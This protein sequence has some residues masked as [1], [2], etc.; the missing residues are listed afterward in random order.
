MLSKKPFC[1]VRASL[2]AFLLVLP[3]PSALAGVAAPVVLH[4]S[5]KEVRTWT[6]AGPPDPH[7]PWIT[8]TTLTAD[9]VAAPM[10]FEVALKMRNFPELQAR[11]ARGELISPAEMEAKYD[12]LPSDAQAVADWLTSQGFVITRQNTD[13]L[14]VFARGTVGQIRQGMQV[15]FGRVSQEGKTYTS[16]VTAPSLPASLSAPVLGVNGLQPHIRPHKH[17]II[18]PASLTNTNPPFLPSQIAQ[19]YDA[20]G[21]YNSNITGSGQ[22]I[23]IIIDTF[24]ATSDLTSFWKT[25]GI[26]QSLNNITFIQVISG[27][28]P[29]TSGE[30]TLDTE[31]SSSIAPGV[32]VR[33]YAAVSLSNV[34]LDQAYEQVYTDVT[35]HPQLGIHQMSM[36]Y[37][38]G[39]TY[40]TLSQVQTDDQYFAELA[41]VGVTVFASAGDGGSTPGS[42]SAGDETGPLQ[43][44]SPAS[45]P[46][47]TGVG[48]TSLTLNTNGSESSEAVWNN[49][50][51]STNYGATGGGTSEYFYRPSWQT[52]TGVPAG[53]MRTVPDVASP[54]DPNTGAVVV[55][56]GAQEEFGGTSWSSPTWAG[57]CALIN[58]ARANAGLSSLGLLGPQIYPLIGTA[59]FRDI[60]SGNNATANSG[61]L[62][63][64]GVGYDPCTGVGVPLVQTLSQTLVGTPTQ[65]LAQIQ[66]A[67]Q[68]IVPGQNATIGVTATGSP[69]GY[70]W[71][72]MPVGTTTWSNLSDNGTY[73]GSA[74]ASL[75]INGTTTAMSGDQFQCVV[76][77]AGPG[78]TSSS[79]SLIVDTPFTIINIAG[80]AGAS[81]NVNSTTPSSAKFSY[82]SGIA[83]DSS[84][85]LFIADYD[86]N[87]IREVTPAGV[88]STPYGSTSGRHGNTNGTGNSARFYNPNAIVADS[89]NNLY[90]ADTSNN[91]IRKITASGAAVSTLATGFNAP[92]GIA[93]DSS[94]NLYVADSGNNVIKKVTSAGSVSI[95]A[96]T[97]G[98]AGYVNA[99]GTAAKFNNPA[100]VA[101]DSLGNVYVADYGNDV[102]RKITSTGVVTLFAGQP[103][104]TGYADGVVGKS[105]FN[106]PGGVAVDGS[107]NV[108]VADSLTPPIGSTAG[109][110]NLL[111]RISTAGVV[112]TIAGQAG[113]TGS[114]S[115]TGTAAQFYSLQAATF[116]SA[117]EVFL[118]DT[119]NQLIRAGGI[120]PAIVTPPLGQVITIGQPV[121]FSVTPTGTGPLTYQWLDNSAALSDA[122]GSTYSI[123]S[124]AAGNAGNYT[125]T[126]TNA[127]GHV[128]SSTATLI[129]VNSQPVAQNVTAGQP[130]T[131]SISVAGP[132]PLAYQWLFNG[133]AISGATGPSYTIPSA[134]SG[135][136]GS[137]S[138]VV[139][140]ANGIVTTNPVGLTVNPAIASDTP[141][142]PQWALILLALLLF[143]V[144]ANV[145]RGK[146]APPVGG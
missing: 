132:G 134:S 77:Y 116:N 128:T 106:T 16:A 43:V 139:S 111:R 55:F 47:V 100:S 107:N 32:K 129:P 8:R 135:N 63:S 61:G 122:T 70:Q 78:V 50:G 110:N 117:G 18:R 113:V 72:R 140:D 45:D 14:A 95:L 96:G 121:S 17:A 141:T 58:Q 22:A 138:V 69:V 46:Y 84:G 31:W 102:V 56:Q 92:N 52:G 108:Y 1:P 146:L 74:T 87:C 114:A 133:V 2:V 40:T 82:P 64:A 91:S 10:D 38:E 112:S 4:D 81:G 27:T 6:Q 5:V 49:L 145:K 115:G 143:F 118:A 103:G 53:T 51:Q 85:D 137:Y 97:S 98:T 11:V 23:A 54:A 29:A 48:G 136:A 21:L 73:T 120:L 9:E 76:S 89:S 119:Y 28:L 105:A 41:G 93:I 66:P 75:T 126:V 67:F 7:Q 71:Q 127:F 24:P 131:F 19:A 25:Y 94:G 79:S 42:G 86:N 80:T 99:S 20:T 13:H 65:P 12:P 35:T 15:G 90:V 57:Y 36:S 44:E 124:V 83:L 101:V 88:V 142:M 60:T 62:Y 144:A 104:T 59:N 123:A 39:E 26:N 125:V 109:G 37:G 34:N 33:V 68:N 130:V 30:E 3:L